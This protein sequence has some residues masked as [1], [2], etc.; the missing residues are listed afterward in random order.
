MALPV[1]MKT[2]YEMVILDLETEAKQ[3]K[4]QLAAMQA[5]LRELQNSITTLRNRLHP[6]TPYTPSNN[7]S[8]RFQ[9]QKYANISVRWAILD[10][11]KDS[12]VA[13]NTAEIAETLKASGIQSRAANFLNNVSAVLSS[14]MQREHNEVRQVNDGK[15]ELTERGKNAIDHIRSTPK[16]QDACH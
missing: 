9:N 13:M 3:V 15:W 8:P 16:F 1:E 7:L 6:D 14:T 11:L 5:K 4:E 2:Q 10:L 12:S